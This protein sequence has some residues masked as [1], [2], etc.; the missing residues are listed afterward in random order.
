ML[1]DHPDSYSTQADLGL[2]LTRLRDQIASPA[3][4]ILIILLAAA[5]VVF[6]IAC[7]NVANL[8]LARSV[9]REGELAVRAA[10]GAS[11]GALRRTLLAESL[12]LCGAGAVLG[13]ALAG[14]MVTIVSQ[15]AARFSV[16]ALEVT[17]D[18]SLLWVGVTLAMVAAVVLAYVPKLP[19][20]HSPTGPSLAAGSIRVTPSTN[21][22]LRVFATTQ[23]AFS[24]VML[25]GAATLLATLIALQTSS[26]G[27][28]MRQVLAADVPPPSLGSNLEEI[29]FY[30]EMQHRIDDLP[31]VRGVAFGMVTPWRDAGRMPGGVPFGAEG[32]TPANGE[33]NPRARFRVV[34]AG[35]FD[36]LGV[37]LLAG[38]DFNA[39]DRRGSEPVAIVSESLARRIFANGGAVNRKL[40]WVDPYFGPKRRELRIV[41]IVAD[42]DDENIV[43]GSALT[44]YHPMQQVA[45]GTRLF[46][47]ADGDPY[48]LVQPIARV[49]RS[50]SATQPFERPAT[51]QDIRTDVLAPERISAFVF[52]GFAGVA[53][54]IAVVGVAG[55]LAFGVSARTREFGVR[56]A[57]GSTPADLLR[58][59]LSEGMVIVSIGIVAGAAFGYVFAGVA[60]AYFE[61][62]RMPGVGSLLGAAGVLAAAAVTASLMPAARASR[63]DVLQALRSE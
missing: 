15:F 49:I 62:V 51:L 34:G 63:V 19:A 25:A 8:I 13:V 40:W 7:S 36:V 48:A 53:L 27:Y 24:F 30:E 52:A 10:L 42:V 29:A 16:R 55:V 26:T 22:R 38:R 50:M 35:F 2:S 33:E 60:A 39:G 32:Y 31:G 20:A 1:R 56:L 14:P 28:N 41:G 18:A 5:A 4:N 3:R 46:V 23:V 21:R 9:R 47:H 37:S 45:M 57:I 58:G 11:K 43:K 17:V 44:V 6:I 12:V 54:L 59:V 61:S